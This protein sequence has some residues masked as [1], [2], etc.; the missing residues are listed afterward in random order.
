MV[1]M[2]ITNVHEYANKKCRLFGMGKNL[3]LTTDVIV[4]EK[5]EWGCYDMM[6]SIMQ[7]CKR[8]MNLINTMCY[9]G[10]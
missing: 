8:G 1:P 5:F 4:K 2:L 9:I 10:I 6:M 7:C 3:T